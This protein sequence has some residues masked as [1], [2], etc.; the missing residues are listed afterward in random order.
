MLVNEAQS[1]GKV[2]PQR[3]HARG[4]TPNG[5]RVRHLTGAL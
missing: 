4:P 5:E 2:A 3:Q 1:T